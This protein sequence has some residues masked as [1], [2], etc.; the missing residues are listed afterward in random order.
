[1]VDADNN[2]IWAEI[3]PGQSMEY[4]I[5]DATATTL[6]KVIIETHAPIVVRI[7]PPQALLH[8]MQDPADCSPVCF[9]VTLGEKRGD[10]CNLRFIENDKPNGRQTTASDPSETFA[11]SR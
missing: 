11:A 7:R 8:D 10:P 2:A 9:P 1:M 3:L 5:E 6:H 4:A